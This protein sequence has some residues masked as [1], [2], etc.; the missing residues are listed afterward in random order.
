M[1][2]YTPAHSYLRH[3]LTPSTH[4]SF[5]VRSLLLPFLPFLCGCWHTI[6]TGLC[7]LVHAPAKPKQEQRHRALEA[8][9]LITQES[10]LQDLADNEED[11]APEGGDG[12][13]ASRAL[14][15]ADDA[16]C[17]VVGGGGAGGAAVA[18]GAGQG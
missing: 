17:C 1:H 12:R 16:G 15:L 9:L 10:L 14:P 11:F 7:I 4:S 8:S 5:P 13:G 6:H 18:G 3:A 2:T